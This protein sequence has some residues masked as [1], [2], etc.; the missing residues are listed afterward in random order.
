MLSNFL[1]QNPSASYYSTVELAADLLTTDDCILTWY[2]SA[3][4][5]SYIYVYISKKNE[6]G[7]LDN[8]S[9]LMKKV[10]DSCV[11]YVKC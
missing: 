2:S 10:G 5:Y 9:F 7:F 11:R 8:N 1:R 4:Q 3:F 6:E